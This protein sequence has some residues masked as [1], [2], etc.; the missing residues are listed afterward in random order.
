MTEMFLIGM[1]LYAVGLLGGYMLGL[2]VPKKIDK[3]GEEE[4]K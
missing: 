4:G 1:L 3:K 2:T